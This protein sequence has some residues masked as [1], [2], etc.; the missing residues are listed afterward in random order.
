MPREYMVIEMPIPVGTNIGSP[1]FFRNL[2]QY[3]EKA[4][5]H[6]DLIRSNP[7]SIFEEIKDWNTNDKGNTRNLRAVMEFEKKDDEY[8]LYSA[9]ES[10]I[11]FKGKVSFPK[12]IGITLKPYPKRDDLAQTIPSKVGEEFLKIASDIK[13][14]IFPHVKLGQVNLGLSKNKSL[15]EL[16]YA[17]AYKAKSVEKYG[18]LIAIRDLLK[19]VPQT[20]KEYKDQRFELSLLLQHLKK[21]SGQNVNKAARFFGGRVSD[22]EKAVIA[23]Q[24]KHPHLDLK[25]PSNA[26]LLQDADRVKMIQE[27]Y[28]NLNLSRFFYAQPSER[29]KLGRGKK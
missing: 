14:E 20:Q 19:E 23:I 21:I 26:K 22:V 7:T 1:N 15:E 5:C 6:T 28:P 12:P 4:T 29:P 3:L 25:F 10:S 13:Q 27:K 9:Q 8:I 16:I 18:T 2:N 17:P 11:Y 24:K